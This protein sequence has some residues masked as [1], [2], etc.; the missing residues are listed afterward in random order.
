MRLTIIGATGNVGR[1]VTTE[2]L[3]R[4]HTV[5]CVLRDP[6]RADH[7]PPEVSTVRGDVTAPDSIATHI[8]ATDVILTAIRPPQGREEQ[9][10]DMTR[11][12]LEGVRGSD[13]RLLSVGGAA[14]LQVGDT[15]RLV[16]D[17]PRYLHPAAAAIA[18]A[19]VDQHALYRKEAD[20]DWTYASPPPSLVDGP[21]T[22]RYRLG[23][24]TLVVD[25]AG[26]SVISVADFAVAIL[27]EVEQPR[28]RRGR[29]TA[30]Y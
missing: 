26:D 18:R 24:D 25:A 19:C 1:N 9:L 22:G 10:V 7:L 2:A 5:T 6:R 17:D 28:H 30:A 21:R 12:L 29:F 27:D 3:R 20:V 23:G 14:T 13:V 16:V 11:E 8:A 4:G 15:G